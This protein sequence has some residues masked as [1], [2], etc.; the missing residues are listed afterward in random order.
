M[1]G[2]YGIFYDGGTLIENSAL[3]FNPPYFGLTVF[4]PG[5][6]APTAAN[7]FPSASG[8]VPP[9]SVNTLAPGGGRHPRSRAAWASTPVSA[10]STSRSAGWAHGARIW[11]GSAI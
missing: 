11:C 8:F 10:A 1:R 4:V 5:D 2:G 6:V 7:P 3:Y 9:A